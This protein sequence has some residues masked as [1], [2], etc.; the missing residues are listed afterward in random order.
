LLILFVEM[1]SD[2]GPAPSSA[3]WSSQSPSKPEAVWNELAMEIVND[4]VTWR[5]FEIPASVHG[6]P[7]PPRPEI[8][9]YPGPNHF[10]A[11]PNDAVECIFRYLSG[12]DL[13][14]V[15][16]T[17]VRFRQLVDGDSSQL[18]W[19]VACHRDFG[20]VRV[21]QVLLGLNVLTDVV[22]TTAVD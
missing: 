8:P 1:Q 21:V 4:D 20:S 19:R 12:V 14:S 3:D 2:A 18:L 9:I 17:C 11:L 10:A 5:P 16:A 15:S 13:A 6:K 22:G 7:V